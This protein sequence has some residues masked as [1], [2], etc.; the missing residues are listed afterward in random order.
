[1]VKQS[2]VS[3]NDRSDSASPALRERPPPGLAAALE[4]QHVALRHRQEIL[5]V[6]GGA[7]RHRLAQPQRG[8]DVGQHQRGGA[9]GHERAVGALQRTGDARVLLAFG[10]AELV[11]RGPCG[12]AHTDC[13]RRSGGSWRRCGRARPTG[14]PSAGS[15]AAAILPKMPAKPPSISASSRTYDALSRLRPISAA[16]VV[17]ICS[18]PTTST[19]RAD[20]AAMLLS[21]WCTAAEPVAQAFSTRS[22]ALEAQFGRGLQHQR[23]GKV[24]RREAGVE[25]A[26]HDLVDIG[27]AD[28]GVRQRF[29][30]HPH[31]QAFERFA[32]EPAEL[33]MRPTDDASRHGDLPVCA[34]D[35]GARR[36]GPAELSCRILDAFV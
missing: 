19:M 30:R 35:T 26:E 10:A 8:L 20:F 32:V 11:A 14:R 25:M 15:T 2:W 34:P 24:L 6:L 23:G 27:R 4:L 5:H 31:D 9:V 7:E 13:R 33:G 12:S 21:P 18:A 29:A 28:A 1:M 36:A 16:G 22:G 17:V 3:T